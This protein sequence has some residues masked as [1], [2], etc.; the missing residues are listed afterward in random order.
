MKFIYYAAFLCSLATLTSSAEMVVTVT[1]KCYP[2]LPTT[3][4][5]TSTSSSSSSSASSTKSSSS[6]MTSSSSA[7][8]TS[9]TSAT[10]SPTNVIDTKCG[11]EFF[12]FSTINK[13]EPFVAEACKQN[14]VFTNGQLELA[15]KPG[16]SPTLSY[17][18]RFKTGRI[19]VLMRA[20][21]GSGAVTALS[22]YGDNKDEVDIELVGKTPIN[23][24]SMYFPKGV[25]IKGL[26]LYHE[27]SPSSNLQETFH[28]YSIE[29]TND[30]FNWFMDGNLV[31]SLP[32]TDPNFPT[33]ANHFKFG[34]WD[35]SASSSWAG[36]VDYNA[37]PIVMAIKSIKIQP[38]C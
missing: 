1:Q 13:I 16:C 28:T 35:G 33:T 25:P 30:A 27:S 37:G 31:R 19:D 24:Q 29:R 14:M 8:K 10:S 3:S 12:D 9:S 26:E 5:T 6:S 7:S 17:P 4:K 11:G 36:V 18:S 15:L 20:A 23:F 34:V 38:Y 22:M 21:N 2:E 32:S